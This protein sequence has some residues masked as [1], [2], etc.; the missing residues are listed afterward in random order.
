MRQLTDCPCKA[1]SPAVNDPYAAI[2][3]VEHLS[4][5]FAA[6]AARSLG[7]QVAYDRT[8]TVAVVVPARSFDEHLGLAVG[9]IRRYGVSE[10]TVACALLRLLGTVSAAADNDPVRLSAIEHKARLIVAGAEREV[11]E[12]ADLDA[13]HPAMEVPHGVLADEG[14]ART[15]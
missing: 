8:G 6:L 7:D 1:L 10:P 4:V 5:L 14:V 2:Q 11:V 3:A 9:L 13:V 15:P 12:P